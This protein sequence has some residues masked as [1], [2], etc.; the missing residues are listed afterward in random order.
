MGENGC[1][2]VDDLMLGDTEDDLIMM[3]NDESVKKK[4]LQM[5]LRARRRGR[6][7]AM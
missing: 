3:M 7:D 5:R 4:R 1:L 2:Y 6:E